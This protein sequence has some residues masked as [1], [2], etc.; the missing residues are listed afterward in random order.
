MLVARGARV[1]VA[2]DELSGAFRILGQSTG[3]ERSGHGREREGDFI[4]D[5]IASG[6]AAPE[7]ELRSLARY[8]REVAA[9]MAPGSRPPARRRRPPA[10]ADGRPRRGAA[11]LTQ[12]I[13]RTEKRPTRET[14]TAVES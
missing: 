4:A 3:A 13:A 6:V 9:A 10:P 1:T 5:R 8:L 14:S 12:K 2:G 11:S 7:Q